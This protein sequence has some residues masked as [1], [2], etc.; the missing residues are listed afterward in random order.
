MMEAIAPTRILWTC[1]EPGVCMITAQSKN[2][3]PF[4]I[5]EYVKVGG[6]EVFVPVTEANDL[7]VTKGALEAY[8]TGRRRD[9]VV[10]M[11]SALDTLE[12]MQAARADLDH[13]LEVIDQEAEEGVGDRPGDHMAESDLGRGRAALARLDHSI[14]YLKVAL[15]IDR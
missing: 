1:D 6:F 3:R 12:A 15:G 7:E 2:G 14:G 5:V 11:A 9:R 8:V 13:L 10:H 4:L